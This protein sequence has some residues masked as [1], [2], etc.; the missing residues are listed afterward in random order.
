M[1]DVNIISNYTFYLVDL[2]PDAPAVD[3][4]SVISIHCE[5][6]VRTC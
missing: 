1:Y 6:L 4:N 2:V 5:L 3:D